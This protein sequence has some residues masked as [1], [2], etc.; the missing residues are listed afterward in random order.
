MLRMAYDLQKASMW[1]RISAFLFDFIILMTLAVGIAVIISALLGYDMVA[2]AYNK[3]SAEIKA[4][5][6]E[7]YKFE[8]NGISFDMK[9]S[10]LKEL[11]DAQKELLT[12][13]QKAHL[14]KRSGDLILQ[15]LNSR[16]SNSMLIIVSL[17]LFLA[18]IIL[19]FAVPLFLRHG[20]TLGK[21]IFGIAVM[22]TNGTK[23]KNVSMF[24]RAILGKYTVETMIP[25][26]VLIPFFFGV[27]NLLG[28]IA[29]LVILVVQVGMLIATKTNSALHDG[30]SSTVV[31]DYA[32]QMIFETE[33]ELV[34]YQRQRAAKLAEERRD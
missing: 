16:L 15:G 9:E 20:R 31:V 6:A 5:I 3:R 10:E 14:E 22:Q 23:V 34:E 4:E 17:S 13:A 18:F 21:R 11:T 29:V 33:A 12:E 28:V 25:V 24:I 30:L 19:E 7:E 32:T 26:Y 8:E 1:K 27:P 2:E